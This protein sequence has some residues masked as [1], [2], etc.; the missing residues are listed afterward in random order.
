M[1][2]V[3]IN[4]LNVRNSPS[5]KS[6]KVAKYDAGQIINSGDLIIMKEGRYWLRYT[7]YSGNERYVCIWEN[8][9]YFVDIPPHISG[10]RPG[11]SPRGVTGIS[12]IP[13]QSQF[14]DDR[15]KRNGCCFLCTCV[16]GGLTNATQCMSCFNWGLSSGKLDNDTCNVNCDKEIWAREISQRYGTTYHDDYIFQNI[17]NHFWLTQGGREIF[18]S[19]GL[20]WHNST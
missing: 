4:G 1:S 17:S 2:R 20:G 14:D 10:P 16:K 13:K 19:A 5:T 9:T 8:G 7:S 18:N 3:L 6:E 12:G 15:I 11:P